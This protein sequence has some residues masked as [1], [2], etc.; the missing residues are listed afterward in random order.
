MRQ[1]VDALCVAGQKM[2]II[3]E[4]NLRKDFAK[5]NATANIALRFAAFGCST[6]KKLS[7]FLLTCLPAGKA[8]N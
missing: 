5:S 1:A 6:F 4:K 8:Q 2:Q 3:D 7:S